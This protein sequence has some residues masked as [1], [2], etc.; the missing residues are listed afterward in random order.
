MAVWFAVLSLVLVVNVVLLSVFST[1]S[2][3][4]DD[5]GGVYRTLFPTNDCGS[6]KTRVLWLQL[7]INVMST[8]A[9]TASGFFAQL[10][11]APTRTEL[12]T[13]HAKK[14]Y[15]LVGVKTF[16]SFPTGIMHSACFAI[17]MLTAVPFHLLFVLH[18]PI[19]DHT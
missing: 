15:H 11:S 13:M 5:V 8:A 12:D 9:L 6:V 1:V 19:S 3:E 16:F 14:T 18:F 4:V 2:T 7:G 10:L 17:L